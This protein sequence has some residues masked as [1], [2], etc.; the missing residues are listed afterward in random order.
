MQLMFLSSWNWKSA[1]LSA[2]LRGSI[3]VVT[4]FRFGF[5]SV[6][7]AVLAEGLFR[8][9]TSGFYGAIAQKMTKVQERWKVVVVLVI[10]VPAIEQIVDYAIHRWRGTPNLLQAMIISCVVMCISALFNWY[11]MTR[12]VLR[13]D[14]GSAS[15]ASDL[16]RLPRL[17]IAF[18]WKGAQSVWRALRLGS[19]TS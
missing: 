9:V 16:I 12:G 18:V 13:T 5:R 8:V 11:V 19:S 7:G 10:A 17:A 15:L 14:P 2:I 3:F 6:A 4:G 1:A